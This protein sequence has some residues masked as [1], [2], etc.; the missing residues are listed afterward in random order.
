MNLKKLLLLL[1]LVFV[2]ASL[3][4]TEPKNSSSQSPDPDVARQAPLQGQLFFPVGAGAPTAAFSPML[5]CTANYL[6]GDFDEDRDRKLSD[7]LQMINCVFLGPNSSRLCLT[8]I[9]DMNCDRRV[10]PVDVIIELR[11]WAA[12][13]PT[14]RS[15]IICLDED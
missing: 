5:A 12:G 13:L 6:R 14:S 2:G 8:C 4:S 1:V 11:M 3:A 10:T 9:C 7:V 15:R